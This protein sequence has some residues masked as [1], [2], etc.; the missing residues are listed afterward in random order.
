M[1][2]TFFNDLRYWLRRGLMLCLLLLLLTGEGPSTRS[3]IVRLKQLSGPLQFDFVTWEIATLARKIAYGL[4][5]PQRFMTDADRARFVLTYLDHVAEA[6]QL[7][8]DIERSYADPQIADPTQATAPQ[9]DSLAALRQRLDR[10]APLAEAILGEQVSQVLTEG[11]F[12]HLSQIVPPVSGTFTPLPYLLIVSPRARIESLFQ[13]E[14]QAGLDAGQ[15][16][17]LETRVESAEPDLSAYVTAIGGLSAYPAMLLETADL[18]W[19][20]D[21]IAHEWTHHTLLR[22]PLGWYYERS[23]EARTINET[24]ASLLGDWA[25]QEVVRRFYAPLRPTEKPLPEPLTLPPREADAP[26]ETFDF[27]AAMHEIRVTVDRLLAEG[28][29][30]EAEAYMEER[31]QYLVAQGYRLRRLNQAYFAFHGA[32]ANQPGAS[33]EDPTGAAVRRL[34]AVSPTPAAFI[35]HIGWATTLEAVEQLADRPEHRTALP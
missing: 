27:H 24:A 33:G 22:A 17:E 30:P 8:A 29:I 14:L 4:L 32:Y 35:Q 13:A 15:Q 16:Q 3:Q 6:Q 1:M 31:R 11:G 18:D 12:G 2:S 10:E 34:W 21:V 26:F 19:A 5:A 7:S 23:A 9:R 20:T 25:G 28:R